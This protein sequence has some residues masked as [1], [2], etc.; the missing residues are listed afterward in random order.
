LNSTSS[1]SYGYGGG[2]YNGGTS[3][4]NSVGNTGNG[5]VVITW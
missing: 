1:Q 5:Q 3:Q 2:S 4:S